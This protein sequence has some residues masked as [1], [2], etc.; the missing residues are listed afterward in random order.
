MLEESRELLKPGDVWQGQC[1]CK[2]GPIGRSA[3][4]EAQAA[5]RAPNVGHAR[6]VGHDTGDSCRHEME[7]GQEKS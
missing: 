5:I 1:L 6:T 4:L 3:K 2:E 7:P